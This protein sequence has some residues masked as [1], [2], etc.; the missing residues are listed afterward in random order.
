[1]S[2]KVKIKREAGDVSPKTNVPAIVL[3]LV[4]VVQA[5][6]TGGWNSPEFATAIAAVISWVV[7]YLSA[8]KVDEDAEVVEPQSGIVVDTVVS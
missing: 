8:D 4:A 1:M 2:D 5:V 7:S 3:L 6:V